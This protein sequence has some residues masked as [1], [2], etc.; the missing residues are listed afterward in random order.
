MRNRLLLKAC[1][2]AAL[3]PRRLFA[4]GDEGAGGAAVDADGEGDGEADVAEP[5]RLDEGGKG[6]QRG[7]V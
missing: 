7:E 2:S 1:E 4:E 6:V 3:V 5:L